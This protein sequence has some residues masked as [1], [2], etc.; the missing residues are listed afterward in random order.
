[1]AVPKRSLVINL[2]LPTVPLFSL[3]QAGQSPARWLSDFGAPG[4]IN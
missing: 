1:M 4:Q 3:V 2:N